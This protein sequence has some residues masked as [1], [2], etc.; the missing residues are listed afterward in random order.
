MKPS[1]LLLRTALASLALLASGSGVVPAGSRECD[2][3]LLRHASCRAE[4]FVLPAGALGR[5]SAGTISCVD[6][7]GGCAA[8]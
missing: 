4:A 3:L 2:A 1:P 6:G 8:Y 5:F 7:P